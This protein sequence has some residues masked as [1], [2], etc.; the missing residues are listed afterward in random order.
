[1]GN[2]YVKVTQI[3]VCGSREDG[4]ILLSEIVDILFSGAKVFVLPW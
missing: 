3:W 4:V 2:I 1:M